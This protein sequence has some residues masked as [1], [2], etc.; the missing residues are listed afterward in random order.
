MEDAHRIR[1]HSRLHQDRCDRFRPAR[2]RRGAGA[3]RR[4]P[5]PAHAELHQARRPDRR[6]LRLADGDLGRRSGRHPERQRGH[7]LGRHL[8]HPPRLDRG[9]RRADSGQAHARLPLLRLL[10][11]G[12]RRAPAAQVPQRGS[13]RQWRAR[14]LRPVGL[15]EQQHRQFQRRRPVGIPER[16]RRAR[17]APLLLAGGRRGA[18]VL[19]DFGRLQGSPG[20]PAPLVRGRD[21]RS[22]VRHRP[23]FGVDH[24][25]LQRTRGRLPGITGVDRPAP[26]RP[27]RRTAQERAGNR[28]GLLHRLRGARR[29]RLGQ[30]Q[31]DPRQHLDR[32][33]RLGRRNR[34]AARHARRDPHRHG[35]VWQGRLRRGGRPLRVGRRRAADPDARLRLR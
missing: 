28:V 32:R 1:R 22:R 26:E 35:P 10:E 23:A 9:G 18:A 13:G 5:A 12:G 34:E 11:P 21:H 17:R 15:Q 16:V 3:V 19:D 25:V 20:V 7:R 30:L 2:H 4:L 29:Q 24:Q 31:P 6:P 27:D 14:H 33:E 8:R